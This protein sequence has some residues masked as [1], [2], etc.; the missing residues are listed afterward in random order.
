MNFVR[1]LPAVLLLCCGSG[2]RAQS[3]TELPLPRPRSGPASIVAGPDHALWFTEYYGN[4]IGRITLSGAIT[5]F[6][7]SMPPRGITTGPDGNIWFTMGAAGM[8]AIGRIT[9]VGVL[10]E[11]PLPDPN[12]F[13]AGIVAGPD[14]ALWFTEGA[15]RIGRVTVNGAITEFE[16]PSPSSG[17]SGIT[18]GPDGNLW[19]VQSNARSIASITLL[20]VVEEHLLPGSFIP[21]HIATGADGALWITDVGAGRLFR[22]SLAGDVSSIPFDPASRAPL[23]IVAG[24]DG[25]LW[26]AE[27]GWF[28]SRPTGPFIVP[29]AIGRVTTTGSL[30]EFLVPN[31]IAQPTGITI[32]PDGNIWFTQFAGN[33]IVRLTGVG[34]RPGRP[35]RTVAVPFR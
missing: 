22:S 5:E 28:I 19:F 15:G 16:V 20:G 21:Q 11:F 32:G 34:L 17:L 25:N 24:P 26:I 27:A 1:V 31:P 35:P 30:T 29:G 2:M 33:S 10:T 7:L 3:F 6:D 8:A 9:P 18:V 23:G 14:G 12:S 4:A 13:P